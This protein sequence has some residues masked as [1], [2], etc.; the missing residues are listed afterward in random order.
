MAQNSDKKQY[1]MFNENIIFVIQTKNFKLLGDKNIE[2]FII[3]DIRAGRRSEPFEMLG[4]LCSAG[5]CCGE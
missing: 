1:L 3:P 2:I 4:C 5:L